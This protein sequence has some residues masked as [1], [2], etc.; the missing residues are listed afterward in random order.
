[1]GKSSLTKVSEDTDTYLKALLYC[2]G[3]RGTAK[4]D[5]PCL[6]SPGAHPSLPRT[7]SEPPLGLAVLS[8]GGGRS[9]WPMCLEGALH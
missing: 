6:P 2:Q 5:W 4:P 7:P 8:Q 1:V 9:P 3:A